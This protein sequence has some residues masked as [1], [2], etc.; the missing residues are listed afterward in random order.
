M[1][2]TLS[3]VFFFL[4]EP[5]SWILIL[6]IWMWVSH[7]KKTK[8]RL[9]ILTL[10]IG[11]LF[12]NTFLYN[13][14]VVAWQ[15]KPVTL[16]PGKVYSAGILLG[17]LSGF[18]AQGRGYFNESADRF[19]ET[20]KLYHQGFIQKVLVSGGSGLLVGNDPK[21]AD[22]LKIQLIASGVLEK[23]IIVENMSRNTYENA[24]FSKR[25]LDSLQVKGPYALI[26][27][28]VHLPRSIKV[29]T[30]AGMTVIPYPSDY[31]G[32]ASTYTLKDLLI[33]DLSLLKN[34]SILLKEIVGIKVYQ[35]TGKA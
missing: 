29:F 12:S 34:W 1:F 17:G 20:Q 26:T 4:V 25:I 30:K 24:I 15:P 28:A 22:F 7:S 5:S 2:F 27:S 13:K 32:I 9:L 21:E 23:D 19:I 35:L 3:K 31:R 11:Y 6:L 16:S 18:D 10:V 8:Q 33:P 14:A